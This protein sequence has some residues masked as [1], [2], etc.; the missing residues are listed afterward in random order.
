MYVCMFFLMKNT[1]K[2]QIE[3]DS[4]ANTKTK[5]PKRKLKKNKRKK[6]ARTIR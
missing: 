1:K 2:N 6:N 4:R 3:I 5:N